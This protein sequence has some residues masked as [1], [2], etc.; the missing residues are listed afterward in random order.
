MNQET[1]LRYA[2]REA[3]ALKNALNESQRKN[4][5]LKNITSGTSVYD[6]IF[7]NTNSNAARTLKQRVSATL[8]NSRG[9]KSENGY[10]PLELLM[11]ENAGDN[12]NSEIAEYIKSNKVT[13]L[14]M[15]RNIDVL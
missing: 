12:Y 5:V 2:R 7:T 6:V 10:T 15:F 11:R 9:E 8:L 13:K 14:P 3:R 1:L 4:L